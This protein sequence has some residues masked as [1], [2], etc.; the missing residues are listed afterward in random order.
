MRFKEFQP[1]IIVLILSFI[2]FV[3]LFWIDSFNKFKLDFQVYDTYFLIPP[4]WLFISILSTL[5][6]LSYTALIIIDKETIIRYIILA[7]SNLTLIVCLLLLQMIVSQ[8]QVFSISFT[9]Y[10]PLSAIPE[11]ITTNKTTPYDGIVNTLLVI[12]IFL[13]LS[14]FFMGYKI[15][16]LKSKNSAG[17]RL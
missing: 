7:L 5:L 17:A 16:K 2:S 9:I 4:V 10:P 6:Y 11:A 13:L 8:L 12:Q 3:L 15:G 1:V 14:L